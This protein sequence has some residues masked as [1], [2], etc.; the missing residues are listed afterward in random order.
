MNEALSA[1]YSRLDRVLHKM[2]FSGIE[3][4]KALADIEDRTHAA[5]MREADESRPVFITALPRAG[6]TLL[7]QFVAKLPGFVSHTY[8]SMPFVLCPLLWESIS[9]GF[10]RPAQPGER[11][12]G[13]GMAVGYD[14]PEA[15]EEVIWK[16]FWPGKYH[17]D[18]IDLWG[19]ADRNEEFERFFHNHM[20]KLIVL[21]SGPG[22]GSVRYVS[23]NNANIA[24][25]PLIRVLFPD[26]VLLVP[27]RDPV[28]QAASLL[29]QHRRFLEIHRKDAFARHY[30]EAIGHFEFGA[31]LRRISFPESP[32]ALPA[33]DPVHAQFWLA[34][35]IS[36]YGYLANLRE[37][38]VRFIDFDEMCRNPIPA[39]RAIENALGLGDGANILGAG[40]ASL[41]EAVRY[42]GESLGL[43]PALLSHAHA[44]HELR[45]R[46]L[47]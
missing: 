47:N 24:R 20:K 40:G 26:A 33:S 42:D 41:H 31:G 11:T 14:S 5:R 7:L 8:R 13:D 37:R 9:R 29:R 23:K 45:N 32:A 3:L 43:D 30:M 1:N 17:G 16:A 19:A 15:F 27:F 21:G 39:M 2:A 44:L 36:A 6:T 34:Y 4:Q 12:H 18:R 10:R 28:N 38:A 35:W 22:S 46:A 25:I